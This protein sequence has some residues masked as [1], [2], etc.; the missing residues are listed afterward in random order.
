[1]IRI[2]NTGRRKFSEILGV[3]V[4]RHN[5]SHYTGLV[6]LVADRVSFE[7]YLHN[8]PTLIYVMRSNNKFRCVTHPK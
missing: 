3:P 4:L 5:T 6:N 7:S 1:M 2:T 8:G